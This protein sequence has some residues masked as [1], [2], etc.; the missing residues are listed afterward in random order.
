MKTK[1]IIAVILFI[2]LC[3]GI[4]AAE[5]AAA[6]TA[7]F[8]A[9]PT[10]GNA[11]LTVT[12][13]DSTNF[14]VGN[15]IDNNSMESG[16]PT[17][18][19]SWYAS[20]AQSS[21]YA[22]SGSKSMSIIATAAT[23][24]DCMATIMPSVKWSFT[25]GNY[26]AWSIW[27][28]SPATV[29]FDP[30]MMYLMENGGS[31][32]QIAAGSIYG[33]SNLQTLSAGT[34]YKITGS[35]YIP[36]DWG[37]GSANTQLV[38]RPAKN[39]PT[40]FDTSHTIYFDDVLLYTEA[41]NYS[42][43]DGTYSTSQNPTHTFDAG[44][45]TVALTATNTIGSNTQ[46]LSNYI[47]AIAP[48]VASF[49]AY[50]TSTLYQVQ[51]NDSSSHYPTSWAWNFGDGN[52]STDQNPIHNY[53]GLSTYTVT[54]TATNAAG[55]NTTNQTVNLMHGPER[56]N[57]NIGLLF[58]PKM[59][60]FDFLAGESSLYQKYT[61]GPIFILIVLLIPFLTLYSRQN[62]IIIVATVYLFG[63]GIISRWMP[64]M[65]GSVAFYMMALGCA[66][67][68]YKYFISRD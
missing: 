23:G 21:A 6:P 59:S 65:F 46:T 68:I 44:T 5:D 29:Q 62:G 58:K 8:T 42:F 41:W 30:S 56:Y 4:A 67:L 2:T 60:G 52:T 22:H 32:R 33:N 40:Q 35:G 12:F 37:S 48:P 10:S 54:L 20:Y 39:S 26:Y 7:S 13:T 14:G 1:Y 9:S 19:G 25:P 38:I 16:L 51:F 63:G 55:S 11:P 36:T 64:A 24:Y 49:T 66:G 28:Y 50:E 15:V 18:M 3:C 31:W 27:V 47:T 53:T 17:S 57:E 45:Y 34:W 43:G 61:P